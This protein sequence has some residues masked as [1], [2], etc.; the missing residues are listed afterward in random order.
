MQSVHPGTFAA[1]RAKQMKRQFLFLTQEDLNSLDFIPFQPHI[2][3]LATIMLCKHFSLASLYSECNFVSG[4]G[5]LGKLTNNLGCK[6]QQA[7]SIDIL[8]NCKR[9][10]ATWMFQPN[11]KARDFRNVHKQHFLRSEQ[12]STVRICNT[13][14]ISIH[15]PAPLAIRPRCLTRVQPMPCFIWLDNGWVFLCTK[16][17]SYS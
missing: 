11:L 1:Q 10:I 6:A 3:M 9:S 8:E 2:Y 5:I 7:P 15:L 13:R 17:A 16:E 4:I 12:S 14:K